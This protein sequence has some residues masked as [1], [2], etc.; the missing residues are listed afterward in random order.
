MQ[1]H[2]PHQPGRQRFADLTPKEAQKVIRDAVSSGV[3][4]AGVL[5]W[6][7]GTVL[8]TALFVMVGK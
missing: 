6:L 2:A 5:L 3:L 4:I 8:V 7:L 1:Q